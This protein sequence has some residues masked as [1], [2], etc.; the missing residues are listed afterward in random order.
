AFHSI[1]FHGNTSF[2]PHPDIYSISGNR[3]ALGAGGISQDDGLV[4]TTLNL[5]L[6]LSGNVPITLPFIRGAG[7]VGVGGTTLTLGGV[8]DGPGGLNV[9]ADSSELILSGANTYQGA[10]TVSG[11]FGAALEIRNASALGSTTGGT[12][13]NGN[14]QLVLEDNIN[15]GAE[16]LTL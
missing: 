10:T 9:T 5:N 2:P 15:V 3:I 7:G 6:T 1:T 11:N 12:I 8:I 13:V 16:P 14:M 4:D